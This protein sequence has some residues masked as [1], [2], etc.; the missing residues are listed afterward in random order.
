MDLSASKSTVEV[1]SNAAWE[2]EGII[3]AMMED[4]PVKSIASRLDIMFV[5]SSDND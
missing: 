1:S 3:P 2:M 5:E 4:A